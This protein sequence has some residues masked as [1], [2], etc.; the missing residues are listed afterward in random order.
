MTKTL[1]NAALALFLGFA[2]IALARAQTIGPITNGPYSLPLLGANPITYTNSFNGS[3]PA[4]IR[5]NLSAPNILTTGSLVLNGTQIMQLSDFANGVTQVDRFV[6]LIGSNSFSFTVAGT[7]GQTVTLTV[8]QVIM[9]T[10]SGLTPNPLALTLGTNGTLTATLSPTPTASGTLSVSSSN[11]AIASVPS[12]IAFAS[13]QASVDIPVTTVGAGSATITAS[14]NGGSASATVNVNAP[15][16]VSITSPTAGTVFTAPASIT[17]TATASDSDGTIAKV[18]FFEGATLLG[19][20]TAAPYS[21]ALANVAAGTHTYS[22]RATDNLGA[23]TTSAA[24]SVTVDAPPVVSLTAPAANAVFAAP[25]TIALAASATDAVGIITKVDFYQGTTLI[26]TA[27]ASPYGF[28]WTNVAAGSYSV[29][30]VATNDAGGTTSSAAVAITVDAAPTVSLTAPAASAVF[31]APASITLTATAA[32]AVGTVTKVDFYQGT[33]LIGTSTAAPY[34][35]TWTNVGSGSYS[36]TAVATN[37]AGMTATSAAT[38]ISV[39]APPAVALTAPAGGATFT[40]PAAIAIAANASDSAGTVT[41]VD[42]YQGGTLIT[43]LTAAPYSFTWAGVPAGSYSLT[44]VATNDAGQSTTSAAVG[45]TVKSAVAQMYFIHPDHLNTPRA[46][47]DA[48]ANV[49]WRWDQTEPFGDSVPNGDPGNTGNV[50]DFPLGLSLYYRDKETGMF[51]AKQRDG[52]SPEIGRFP[53]SDPI[54]LQGGLNLYQYAASNP[55]SNT[56]PEGLQAIPFPRFPIPGFPTRGGSGSSNSN[57][58]GNSDLDRALGIPRSGPSSSSSSSQ[59][60][61]PPDD[62]CEKLRERDEAAC[63]LLSGTR[64]G[65]RGLA[66]CMAS[67]AQR[68]AECLRFGP[69]GVKTPLHG[70]DTPL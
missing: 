38:S 13:G 53:Q 20:S 52:Y 14:A 18:E 56:D 34:S 51:Y 3:G 6:T 44:A 54:G 19:T 28:S 9:P 8:Y 60:S 26:G 2:L 41:K 37:D 48:S 69:G 43:S 62:A 39:D 27:T 70:V 12:S 57:S 16:T 50:F 5:V 17:I 47:S 1:K 59:S 32:D 33:T 49:V 45:I 15:P 7:R 25:A 55:L 40:A 10:P 65:S 21:V 68:Y 24:V 22:A 64:Y 23:A 66:L 35:F 31:A 29:T 61:C 67:A 46:V 11:T 58:T 30:A 63:G 36:L 4:L 42:F